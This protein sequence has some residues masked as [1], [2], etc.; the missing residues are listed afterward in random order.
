[1]LKKKEEEKTDEE[2]FEL[3]Y[4]KQFKQKNYFDLLNNTMKGNQNLLTS[5]NTKI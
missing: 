5:I 1:M 2:I 3:S 4:T